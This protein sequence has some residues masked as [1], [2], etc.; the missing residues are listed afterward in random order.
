MA[1][2]WWLR[3]WDLDRDGILHPI[4]LPLELLPLLEKIIALQIVVE[5]YNRC[6]LILG[7]GKKLEWAGEEE[8]RIVYH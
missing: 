6:E 5:I 7:R 4:H 3:K 1:Q 8:M 2:T